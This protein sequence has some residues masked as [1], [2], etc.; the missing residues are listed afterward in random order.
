[1][2]ALFTRLL[3]E[4][5]TS[6]KSL[7]PLLTTNVTHG[8][9]YTVWSKTHCIGFLNYSSFSKNNYIEK[10]NMLNISDFTVSIK[11]KICSRYFRNL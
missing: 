7:S 4:E 10:A 11:I 5:L 3:S 6:H 8:S 2:Q 9:P 1:M